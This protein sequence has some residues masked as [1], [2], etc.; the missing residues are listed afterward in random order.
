MVFMTMLMFAFIANAQTTI[1][2]AITDDANDAEEVTAVVDPEDVLGTM[3]LGSSDLEL[4]IDHSPQ[5]VGMLF[6]GLTIPVGATVTSATIEFDDQKGSNNGGTVVNLYAAKAA[7]VAAILE[8]PFFL[9]TQPLTTATVAWTLPVISAANE[10]YSCPDLKS[11]FQEVIGIAGWAPG[12]NV[13]VLVKG[14]DAETDEKNNVEP[15]SAGSDKGPG[16]ILTLTY[17]AGGGTAVNSVSEL[18]SSVYPNPTS[19]MLSIKNP[20]SDKFGYEV[21]TIN[22]KMVASRHNIAGPKAD[23][24]MSSFARGVYFVNVKNSERTETH[25]LIVK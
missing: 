3:D 6:T 4:C 15:N 2:M 5:I 11:I 9:S 21:F 18:S 23:L 12:N 14:N 17:T 16:P 7:N 24:D 10:K 8:T 1:T 13:L 25:K 22:G 20:S 19:G